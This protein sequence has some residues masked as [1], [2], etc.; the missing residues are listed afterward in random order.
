MSNKLNTKDLINIGI[1]TAIYFAV[2]YVTGM[3]GYIPICEVLVPLLLPLVTGI[4][5]MLFLT[6][7]DKFGMVTIMGIIVSLILFATGH[8]WLVMAVGIPCAVIADLILKS[9]EYKS[10]RKIIVGFCIFSE[11][12][13]GAMLPMWI[14]RDAYFDRIRAGYGDEYTDTL[15]SLMSGWMIAVMALMVVVG[16]IAGAYIG[17]STLKRHFERAGIA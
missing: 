15:M 2:F 11:W 5:F 3:I 4:P 16:G 10:W 13:M 17:R 12:I 14:M 8:S 7:I 6:K 9:G 1:F